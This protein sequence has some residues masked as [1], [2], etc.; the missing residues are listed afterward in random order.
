MGTLE[1]EVALVTGAARGQG[2]AHAVTLAG[3]GA[4][5]IAFD[6]PAPIGTMPYALATSAE[7]AETDRLV[8]GTGRRV[9]AFEGDVRSP[10]TPSTLRWHRGSRPSTDRHL[11]SPTP[12]S[13]APLRR[14]RCPKRSGPRWWTSTSPGSGAPPRRSSPA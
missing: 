8:E 12:A 11:R 2:R 9:V 13:G 5:V 6:V 1:G 7:L 10:R 14:G 4:D 3:E